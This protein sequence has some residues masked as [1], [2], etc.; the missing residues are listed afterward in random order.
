M[1]VI[2][3][4]FKTVVVF[5]WNHRASPEAMSRDPRAPVKGQ[6]LGSTMW[7]WWSWW[8]IRAMY[9]LVDKG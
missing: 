1:R 9:F 8:V 7:Y 5:V 4:S 6:G 3:P 2:R